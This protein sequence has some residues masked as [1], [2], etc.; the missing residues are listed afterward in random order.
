[1]KGFIKQIFATFFGIVLFCV[2]AVILGVIAI[3]QVVA[4][5]DSD[6]TV[7]KN[8]ILVIKFDKPI[9]ERSEDNLSLVDIINSGETGTIGLDDILDAIKKA[10]D[11]DNIKGIYIDADGMDP[12]SFAALTA[13]HRALKDFK[14]SGKWIIS[15]AD[16]YN[17]ASYYV[18]STADKILVNPE[19][20]IDWHGLAALGVYYKDALAK[21]GIKMQVSKVGKYKSAV[22]AFTADGRSDA[23]REQVTAYVNRIWNS[24]CEGISENRGISVDSLNAMADRMIIFA[25]AEEYV[26]LGLADKLVYKRDVKSEIKQIMG[27]DEDKNLNTIGL[28]GMATVKGEKEK[29]KQ[30]AVYYAYGEILSTES[31]GLF[32]GN[33][34][35]IIGKDVCKDIEELADDDDVKAVVLRVNSPGGSAFVSE[36]I[37]NAL[38]ELKQKKPLVVSMGG[39]AASGGYYISSIADWIVAEPTTITGSIGIF[40]LFQDLS[41]LWTEKIGFKYDCIKTNAHSDF[42]RPD[43]PF[44]SEE[45]DMLDTYIERGYD[46][47]KAR[48]AEG[49]KIS[50]DSVEQIAQ[51]RVWTGDDALAV[52]LV[53]RLGGIDEAITK[54]AELAEVDEFHTKA[55]PAKTTWIDMLDIDDAADSY[56]DGRMQTLLGEHY[57]PVMLLMSAEKLDPIQARLPYHIIWH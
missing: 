15:Y 27:L 48:V 26:R 3:V 55:Y 51:G 36:Q 25:D 22:E 9:E 45:I 52:G 39:Y 43:R 40:G 29:G 30:I 21:I 53:D 5:A 56:I 37:W 46:L 8:S 20:E 28:A 1:M 12:E 47:F 34:H 4:T 13:I 18:C 41:E 10:K 7:S 35:N 57:R 54:A 33:G 49:R 19:G 42:G 14:A 2:V 23:D 24:L 31:D 6:K 32:S 50:A 11:N 17:A 44:N 16:T 38:N